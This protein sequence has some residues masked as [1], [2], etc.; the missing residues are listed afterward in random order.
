MQIHIVTDPNAD[1][2]DSNHVVAF[3]SWD[4]AVADR[5]SKPGSTLRT[6]ELR[7]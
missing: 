1:R 2:H 4:D 7:E 5:E 3:K 6:A